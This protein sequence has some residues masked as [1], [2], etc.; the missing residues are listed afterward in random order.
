MRYQLSKA[1]QI[2]HSARIQGLLAHAAS[3][4]G[5][6]FR[7]TS[8]GHIEHADTNASKVLKSRLNRSVLPVE[9]SGDCPTR[10]SRKRGLAPESLSL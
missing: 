10:R 6:L 9:G 8:C 7:C 4:K 2:L 5:V 1:A 3:R